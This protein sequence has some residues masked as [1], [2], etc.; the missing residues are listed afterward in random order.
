MRV[1]DGLDGS[2]YSADTKF[3]ITG[4]AGFTG[5]ALASRLLARGARVIVYDNFTQPAAGH[6]ANWLAQQYGRRVTVVRGDVRAASRLAEFIQGARA[7]FHLA[8]GPAYPDGTAGPEEHFEVNAL[9]TLN[10]LEAARASRRPPVVCYS[11][12]SRVYG[13]RTP[14]PSGVAESDPLDMRTHFG[15]S[16]GAGDQYAADYARTYGLRTIVFRQSCIY[17]PGQFGTEEQGWVA[18]CAIRAIAGLPITIHG[19]GKQVRDVLYVDD[20]ISAYEAALHAPASTAGPVYNI[21]GGPQN[22]L[23]PLQLIELLE[24]FLGSRADVRFEPA[25]P[26]CPDFFVADIEKARRDLGW[27]PL[28][29]PAEGV[30]RLVQ[31]L[32]T[33]PKVVTAAAGA[34]AGT[35]GLW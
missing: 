13:P 5:A 32:K 8:A 33:N 28:V 3:L 34:V 23:T 7:V 10:L 29:P 16:K 31:W 18:R 19:N 20:L 26:G 2:T 27:K 9:G 15:C 24:S 14:R 22:T 30:R 6:N 4:G 12:T 11:S 35:E 25:Q 21:G 1:S 17:G